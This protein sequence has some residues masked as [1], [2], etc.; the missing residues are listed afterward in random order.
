MK[1]VYV[2]LYTHFTHIFDLI[3]RGLKLHHPTAPSHKA[4]SFGSAGKPAGTEVS[5]C[6]NLFLSFPS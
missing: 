4:G 3:Q 5:A 6:L 2:V 1:T